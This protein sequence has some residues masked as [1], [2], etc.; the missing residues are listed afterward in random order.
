MANADETKTATTEKNDA[1]A[2]P[3]PEPEKIKEPVVLTKD[4]ELK[5]VRQMEY[6]FGD[7][8]LP[9]DKFLLE[10]TKLDDGWVPFD[11]LLTFKRLQSICDDADAIAKAL[12]NSDQNLIIV[13]DDMKKVRRNPEM[14][15]PEY[16]EERRKELASRTAYAKGFPADESLESVEKFIG[17]HG[18]FDSILMR[19]YKDKA[20]K[21]QIFKG[22]IM[23]IFKDVE[24]CKKFIE[25]EEIKFKD[26]PLIRKWQ[27]DYMEE[28]KK[29]RDE[30]NE[31]KNKYKT[32][33]VNEDVKKMQFPKGAILHM[34]GFKDDTFRETI[35][36]KVGEIYDSE[37]AYITF[38]KGD[39]EGYIRFIDENG[40][41]DFIKKLG[42]KKLVIDEAEIV[43]RSL[44]GEE[45]QKFL[46]DLSDTLTKMRHQHKQSGRGRKRKGGRDN[47]PR[48]KHSRRD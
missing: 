48:N 27:N 26:T 7:I 3:A 42:D 23:V 38:D 32:K 36:T 43:V 5:I 11:V 41:V 9:R 12:Q 34:T 29:E 44:E 13:S 40:A 47:G 39:K 2:E 21:K 45:E 16:N 6:Y 14:P 15:M 31:K 8:N 33:E 25:A 4:L 18:A 35:K 19:S 10:Q 22:S 1:T 17:T 37:I 30:R 24:S 46:D 28:K 20:L